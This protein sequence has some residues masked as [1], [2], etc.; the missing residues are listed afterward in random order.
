VGDVDISEQ[1]DTVCT[2]Q[3][4]SIRL[5][6]ALLCSALFKSLLI[7]TVSPDSRVV[8]ESGVH[9]EGRARG[10]SLL[11]GGGHD[12][13]VEAREGRGREGKRVGV[14]EMVF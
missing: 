7:S 9:Q 8:E 6:S 2:V 4:I 3:F 1:P 11:E 5:N 14:E 13:L 12:A 10:G